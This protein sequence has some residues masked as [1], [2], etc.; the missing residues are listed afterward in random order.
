MSVSSLNILVVQGTIREGRYSIHPAR[1]VTDRF[2]ERGHAADLFDMKHYDIPL[3]TN[4]R[5]AVS[6][7]HPDV[8]AFGQR[9]EAADALVIVA[10]EYNHSIPGTLKNL[11]DHLYPEYE[12]TAFSY[13]TVSAGGFGGVRA[14]SHLHDITLEFNAYPGPDLPVSNVRDAF[15]EDGTLIDETY[16]DRFEEFIEAVVEHAEQFAP[17]PVG[18]S[19]EAGV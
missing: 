11:L 13:V 15:D 10:P 16:E 14:L 19:P 4:R 9:V 1:Y 5:D 18:T 2:R 8:D 6:D 12:E 7:P 17:L 3:F